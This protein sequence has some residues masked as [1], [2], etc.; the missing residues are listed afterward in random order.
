MGNSWGGGIVTLYEKF[1]G[2]GGENIWKKSEKE[3][4]NIL[5]TNLK[6]MTIRSEI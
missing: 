5:K 4:E 2:S 3:F 6:K 1:N